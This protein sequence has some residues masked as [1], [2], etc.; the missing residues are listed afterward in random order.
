M[1][2]TTEPLTPRVS[3]VIATHNYAAFLPQA[4]ESVRS[5][6]FGDWE[7]LIVDDASTDTTPEIAAAACAADPRFRYLRSEKNLGEA[8]TRNRG[9]REARGQWIATLDADDWWT[10]NKLASQLAAAETHPDAHIVFTAKVDVHGEQRQE[11]RCP[12]T[13]LRTL[14]LTL[15]QES[16]IV[17]SSTLIRRDAWETVGGYDEQ[18]P[19]APDWELWL[20]LLTHFGVS[21]FRYVDEPLVYYRLH[22]SNISRNWTRMRRAEWQILRRYVFA[23]GWWLRHPRGAVQAIDEQLWR[24][25]QRHREKGETAAAYRLSLARAL[26]T[27][28]R[29]W[30]WRLLL[31]SAR[32]TTAAGPA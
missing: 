2:P 8:G 25:V 13:W 30:R 17:H 1:T 28:L 16:L 31:R 10:P 23:N 5:Q 4:L 29:P 26:L 12:E 15:R 7:C 9:N 20:R 14:P 18:I 32:P 11:I 3:V 27:P 24:E 6:T 19:T 22:G 21:A